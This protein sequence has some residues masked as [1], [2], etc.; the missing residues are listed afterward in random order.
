VLGHFVVV[1]LKESG[2]FNAE[3]NLNVACAP[4]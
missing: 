4:Q 3:E 2:V 1:K